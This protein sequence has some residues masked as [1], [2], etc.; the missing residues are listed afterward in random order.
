MASMTR[1]QLRAEL[2]RAA[3]IGANV[4]TTMLDDWL[5]E[6]VKKLQNETRWLEKTVVFYIREY[7]TLN[8]NEGFKLTVSSSSHVINLSTAV[9]DISGSQLASYLQS[10]IQ[11]SGNFNSTGITVSYSTSDRKFTITASTGTTAIVIKHPDYSTSINY[12][13]SYKLFG[14]T[15]P[16]SSADTY[17]ITGDA[18]P[19]CTSE[20]PL[21]SDFLYVKE[22]R[23]DEKSYPLEAASY[24]DR[25]IYTGV[26]KYYYIKNSRLGLIPQPTSGGKK[27]QLDYYYLPSDF[28]SDSDTHPFPESFN[29]AIIYYAAMLYKDYQGDDNGM[30]K[31]LSMYE[32]EKKFILSRKGSRIGGGVY[33]LGGTNKG[34]D[35]RRY[36]L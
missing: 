23:Y 17:T 19:W 12:D 11:S 4:S 16:Q 29:Y 33:I 26:P 36:N 2:K 32:R 18:A 10:E 6:A 14:L 24:K 20:Y 8:T 21:P 5:Y 7:F 27:I 35:P 3:R 13:C 22:I 28:T 25:N 34:Y 30:A 9:T 1:A 15:D 31:F